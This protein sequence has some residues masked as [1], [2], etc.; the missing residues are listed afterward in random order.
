M[1]ESNESV[2]R[3][4]YGGAPV[5]YVVTAVAGFAVAGLL[6]VG[7]A[8]EKALQEK[9]ATTPQA[10]P[11]P[12]VRPGMSTTK[13]PNYLKDP[14]KGA[15]YVLELAKKYGDNFDKLPLEDQSLLNGMSSG[16]G[17]ELLKSRVATLKEA[18]ESKPDARGI[19]TEQTEEAPKPS[20]T[21]TKTP[22]REPKTP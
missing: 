18:E 12:E 2:R 15:A 11:T 7:F 17:R 16:H 10:A 22:T 20:E 21:E 4:L 9:A 13:Q 14:A 19:Q 3:P 5:P 6:F 1:N 8:Q